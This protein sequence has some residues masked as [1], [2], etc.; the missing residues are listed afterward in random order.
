MTKYNDR[1]GIPGAEVANLRKRW[2]RMKDDAVFADFDSFVLWASQ[3]GYRKGL[4]LRRYDPG[5]PHGPENSFY[6][7][8]EAADQAAKL[9][10]ERQK[11]ERMANPVECCRG[12]EK[13]CP[14]DGGGQGCKV[15]RDWF[16]KN[17][18]EKI[19]IRPKLQ[20][21]VEDGKRQF[22]RYEHPDLVREGIG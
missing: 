21:P 15:W 3:N 10:K 14:G 2:H 16:V 20:A 17:W 1:Y 19:R 11:A 18:N 13:E 9:E 22:F 4:E 8:K 6:Y 5:K 7:S 12:C